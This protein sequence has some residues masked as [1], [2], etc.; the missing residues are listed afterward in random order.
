MEKSVQRGSFVLK[1]EEG[2][3]NK[4]WKMGRKCGGKAYEMREKI[5]QLLWNKENGRKKYK[6]KG[7]GVKLWEC[8]KERV[9][10]QGNTVKTRVREEWAVFSHCQIKSHSYLKCKGDMAKC[11]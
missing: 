1:E 8:L 4:W 5:V 3:K 2:K 11:C 9:R 10:C 7:G 6:R